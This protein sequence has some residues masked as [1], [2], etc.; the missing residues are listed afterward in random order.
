MVLAFILLHFAPSIYWGASGDSIIAPLLWSLVG[1]AYSALTKWRTQDI[2]TAFAF[3][4]GKRRSMMLGAALTGL[5]FS[6]ALNLAG[7]SIGRII[8]SSS[9]VTR[10]VEAVVIAYLIAGLHHV[11]CDLRRPVISQPSY[12]RQGFS[13]M[14]TM[15]SYGFQYRFLT[16]AGREASVSGIQSLI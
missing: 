16:C 1:A 15:V 11:L 13:S 2:E 10:V 6:G 7:Y 4:T 3:V 8:V 9:G 14:L 12:V 5:L